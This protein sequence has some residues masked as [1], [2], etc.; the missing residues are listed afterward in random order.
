MPKYSDSER[1]FNDA[2][3]HV[4]IIYTQVLKL[5]NMFSIG[6][7][8]IFSLMT[9]QSDI[10]Q[11]LLFI[12]LQDVKTCFWLSKRVVFMYIVLSQ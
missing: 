2:T 3:I 8:L 7:C 5:I 12:S 9:P 4:A 6:F 1:V 11:S 10:L